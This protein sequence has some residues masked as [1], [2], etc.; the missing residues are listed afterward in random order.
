MDLALHKS[1][2]VRLLLDR[3]KLLPHV[4]RGHRASAWNPSKVCRD[5]A[6]APVSCSPSASATLC[7][8]LNRGRIPGGRFHGFCRLVFALKTQV[9]DSCRSILRIGG[10]MVSWFHGFMVLCDR[11]LCLLFRNRIRCT[12]TAGSW[13]P[14]SF[15]IRP[16]TPQDMIQAPKNI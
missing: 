3:I 16:P 1:L 8:L 2:E 14:P 13:Q 9:I 7:L 5:S 6:P 15:S 11:K 12:C 10:L 4:F